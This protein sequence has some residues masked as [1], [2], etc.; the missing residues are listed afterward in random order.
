MGGIISGFLGGASNAMAEAG[1]MMLADKLTKEREEA[2]FL[3]ESELRKSMQQEGFRHTETQTQAQIDSREHV[4]EERLRSQELEGELN[5]QNRLDI[6]NIGAAARVESA[7]GKNATM[8]TK[9]KEVRDLV[10]Q[11]YPK[12]RAYSLVFGGLKEVQDKDT[13]DIVLIDTLNNDQEVGRLTTV[14]G[15][16]EWIPAGQQPVNAPV[17]SAE[18]KQA[19]KNASEIATWGNLDETDFGMSRKEWEKLEAQRLANERRA[20]ENKQGRTVPVE[21]PGIVAPQAD[22]PAPAMTDQ[23]FD[24]TKPPSGA[25]PEPPSDAITKPMK[26]IMGREMTRDQFIKLV[27]KREPGRDP[28]KIGADWDNWDR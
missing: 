21:Q 16:K 15:K 9:M 18:R 5:R 25:D 28:K 12:D 23:D 6:A 13:N 26:K 17:T 3:R 20:Q 4:A 1:K 27:M 19:K 11:G 22:L 2:N 14:G 10:G 7:S 8:T 24:A